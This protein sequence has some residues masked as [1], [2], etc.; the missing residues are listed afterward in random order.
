MWGIS[1]CTIIVRD[2]RLAEM[3]LEGSLEA[4]NAKT[5]RQ[6]VSQDRKTY[7]IFKTKT[8]SGAHQLN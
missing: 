4:T 7:F 1:S 5:K 8:C 6:G 2:K 3:K